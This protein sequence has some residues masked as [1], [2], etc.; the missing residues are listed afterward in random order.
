MSSIRVLTLLCI[1][2][3]ALYYLLNAVARECSGIACDMF[4]PLSLLL[5]L[6]TVVTVAT[7]GVFATYEARTGPAIWVVLLGT[8]SILGGLGPVVALLALRNS[9]DI[10][11]P[12]PTALELLVP[13][14]TL[15][16]GLMNRRTRQ[17]THESGRG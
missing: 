11:V 5:P 2:L 14:G 8:C 16:Y 9:P 13:A 3:I 7:T 15:G 10:L 17:A 4:I 1:V 12:L 6:I